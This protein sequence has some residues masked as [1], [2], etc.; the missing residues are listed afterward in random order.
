MN[1]TWPEGTCVWAPGAARTFTR[2]LWG[3]PQG[4]TGRTPG[5]RRLL[6]RL[7]RSRGLT[8]A[9]GLK[10]EL[11]VSWADVP[12]GGLRP[13]VR[14][15]GEVVMMVVGNSAIVRH[16]PLGTNI[17]TVVDLV[18]HGRD[19]EGIVAVLQVDCI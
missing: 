18:P 10:N 7:K 8:A 19:R 11:R 4:T 12:T 6:R 5:P 1:A 2:R 13:A 15:A 3:F 14:S 16:Q 17:V 9:R